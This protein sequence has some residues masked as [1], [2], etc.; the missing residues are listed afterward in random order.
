MNIFKKLI[1]FFNSM[2]TIT[3]KLLTLVLCSIT[4]PLIVVANFSTDTIKQ[5]TIDNSQ[6]QIDINKKIFEKKYS[7]ELNELKNKVMSS[8]ENFKENYKETPYGFQSKK[9]INYLFKNNPDLSFGMVL[10]LNENL[11][12]YRGN[13][14]PKLILSKLSKLIK[15]SYV[16][17]N[18]LSSENL[19][20]NIFQI[21]IIPIS[22][23]NRISS[24]IIAGKSIK[25]SNIISYVNNI[26]GAGVV[27]YDKNQ[28]KAEIISVSNNV[29]GLDNFYK[30]VNLSKD[31]PNYGGFYFDGNNLLNPNDFYLNFQLN[32]YFN[33]PIG[34]VYVGIPRFNSVVW[35]NRNVKLIGFIAV[36]SMFVAII[37]AALFARKITDP[38]LY[39]KEAAES[40][41]L[42]NLDYRVEIE[43][44]D[45]IVKLSKSFNKM[46]NN[47]E[48]DEMLRN[49][50]VATL[51]HDL[52]VPMLAENQTVTYLL[53]ETYGPL[54]EEQKEVLELIK[55]T[56][57]S[58]LEMIGTL[59]E[60]YRYDCGN[61]N[62]FITEFDLVN[63]IKNTVNQIKSLAEDK[64]IQININSDC[65]NIMVNADER[66]IKR[67]IHNLASNS[68]NHGI[69]RGFLNCNI[70]VI[71]D[72]VNYIP[73][74]DAES[75][76]SLTKSLKIS[77]SVL[78]SVEDNGVGI[79]REDMPLLF[80]R[81]SLSKG[82]KPAGS[83]LGLYYAKQVVG[84]H[85]GY[86]WAES[87]KNGGS[88]FKFTLP[89][90]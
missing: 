90:C 44:N 5:S 29:S 52:K 57:I 34:K 24:I 3:T 48:R 1:D 59:L 22:I 80:N 85:K 51:T 40:I 65:E 12:V 73:K 33:E 70:E 20:N 66:D 50:F 83:G 25:N 41:N 36:I 17:D 8:I 11:K 74:A 35:I 43:G 69:H 30:V 21:A 37:I 61:V 88:T 39:L 45:E 53:K 26:T 31:N 14:N 16:G 7:D 58:S 64:K 27:I 79:S 60:V 56:N 9:F 72:I 18:L 68:I 76:T 23:N 47:L 32:N 82:R 89:L 63:T 15:I 6:I 75:Y 86:I 13:L 62:L 19:G 87:S 81:F 77:N 49:N 71:N 46:I 84:L 28:A 4:I 10:D 42:G 55:S 78:I 67:L 54:T 2:D 38:I